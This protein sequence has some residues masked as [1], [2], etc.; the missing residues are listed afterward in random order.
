[1]E[2]IL[3]LIFFRQNLQDCQDILAGFPDENLQIPIACGDGNKANS[4]CS[5][6]L[7][8][9]HRFIR[10]KG[11]DTLDFSSDEVGLNILIFFWKM[12]NKKILKI[13]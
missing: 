12:R 13:L 2:W 8:A 3:I 4:K 5:M 11:L 1:M 10:G 6:C 9:Y 7:L